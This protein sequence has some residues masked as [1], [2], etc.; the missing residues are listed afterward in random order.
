MP[1]ITPL[2]RQPA[3]AIGAAR[4]SWLSGSVGPAVIWGGSARVV[5]TMTSARANSAT[6][7]LNGRAEVTSAFA[8]SSWP[9]AR[10]ANVP[11]M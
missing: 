3:T 6:I 5:L 7:A 8:M 1:L 10:A 2:S 4:V 11:T 9:T